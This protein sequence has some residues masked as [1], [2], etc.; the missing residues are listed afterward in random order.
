[1]SDL[2][3]R[4]AL[5][6]TDGRS[7]EVEAAGVQLF[8]YVYNPV[9]IPMEESPKPY[10]H[11]LKTLQGNVMTNLRANDHPWHHAL[12]MTV[13]LLDGYN[14]WGGPTYAD[15]E[16]YRWAE[17]HGRQKHLEWKVLS[18]SDDGT[19]Q[20]EESL[21][22]ETLKGE[23]LL[24][25]TRRIGIPEI[26]M[27]EGYW[28]LDFATELENVSGRDLTFGNYHSSEG[29]K[30]SHY[31]GLLFRM[32]REFVY[33]CGDPEI[34]LLATNGLDGEDDVHGASSPWLAMVGRHDET[35]D[36]STV[37]FLDRPENETYPSHWFVR[38]ALPCVAYTFQYDE[39]RILKKG[40]TLNLSYRM[41]IANGA[42]SREKIEAFVASQ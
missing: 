10:F 32:A 20:M 23:G 1:M 29:L 33:E 39:D 26:S 12:A 17:N 36:R 14:F 31:T 25:E 6:H 28:V 11:P 42:W 19:L 2:K 27:E 16:G 24:S 41:V 34:K 18:A 13:T 7:V 3:K 38:R 22:W 4:L 15:G 40:E 37:L 9:E 21:L 30:G 35:L 8:S 5:V